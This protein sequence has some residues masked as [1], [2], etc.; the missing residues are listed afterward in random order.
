MLIQIAVEPYELGLRIVVFAVIR[1][2]ASVLA[3]TSIGVSRLTEQFSANY[4]GWKK[5]VVGN[6]NEDV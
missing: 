6:Y 4:L 5:Y 2:A 1:W 3:R